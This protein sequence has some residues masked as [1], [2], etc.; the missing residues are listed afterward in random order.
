MTYTLEQI[1]AAM[2]AEH[3]H[4]RDISISGV[5]ERLSSMTSDECPKCGGDGIRPTNDGWKCPWCGHAWKAHVTQSYTT[6]NH[7]EP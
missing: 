7:I 6:G 1:R 4:T 3:E 2:R 5:I